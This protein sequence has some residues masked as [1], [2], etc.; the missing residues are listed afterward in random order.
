MLELPPED[1]LLSED[2]EKLLGDLSTGSRPYIREGAAKKLANLTTSAN[3]IVDELMSAARSE[4]P[5]VRRAAVEAL[6]A[7]AHKENLERRGFK[8]EAFWRYVYPPKVCARCKASNPHEQVKCTECGFSLNI[9]PA[10]KGLPV[11]WLD[12][13]GHLLFEEERAIKEFVASL[14]LERYPLVETVLGLL[15]A[16]IAPFGLLSLIVG[17]RVIFTPFIQNLAATY[18]I[19][20]LGAGITYGYSR[21]LGGKES[22]GIHTYLLSLIYAPITLISLSLNFLLLVFFGE[23][24]LSCLYIVGWG[25]GILLLILTV[26]VLRYGQQLSKWQ[27][28]LAMV[29]SAG[30]AFTL[31]LGLGIGLIIWSKVTGTPLDALMIYTQEEQAQE[32]SRIPQRATATSQARER[33]MA[34]ETSM[35]ATAEVRAIGRALSGQKDLKSVSFSPDGREFA[36]AGSTVTIWDTITCKAVITLTDNVLATGISYS[37]DGRKLAT[38]DETGMVKLWDTQTWQELSTLRGVQDR[39]NTVTFSPDGQKLVAKGE[40]QLIVWD[41][42][43]YQQL[44][45]TDYDRSYL[46]GL[47]FNPKGGQFS[48]VVKGKVNTVQVWQI[49]TGEKVIN[50]GGDESGTTIESARYNPDGSYMAITRSKGMVEIWDTKTWQNTFSFQAAQAHLKYAVYSPDGRYIVTAGSPQI[51][52]WEAAT[53]Q[54]VASLG[55]GTWIDLIVYSP[56]GRY[57]ATMDNDE[58]VI[59][60]TTILYQ[61]GSF[62][63]RRVNN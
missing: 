35:I 40:N 9:E 5:F 25:L 50:F 60:D 62:W 30:T 26:R 53:G 31:A 39:Y 20:F 44:Y 22:F 41:V 16:V 47:N 37:P 52:V 4:Y 7:P 24:V 23:D 36:T 27:A 2:V 51:K 1:E 32:Q 56:D 12:V 57:V 45:K 42:N 3:Y 15:G 54:E 13:L 10:T 58:L 55:E 17:P 46:I 49:D 63:A 38:G 61:G 6:Q 34:T 21:L 29:M 43:S 19:F 33:R 18:I 14:T 11:I 59:W 48:T 8:A 28:I